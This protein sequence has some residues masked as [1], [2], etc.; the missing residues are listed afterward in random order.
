[1][2]LRHDLEEKQNTIARLTHE[3]AMIRDELSAA[4]VGDKVVLGITRNAHSFFATRSY[5]SK[6]CSCKYLVIQA[7]G[8][9][10]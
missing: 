7:P 5:E 2:E 9:R 6:E 1:M 10:R 4:N 8:R 3:N